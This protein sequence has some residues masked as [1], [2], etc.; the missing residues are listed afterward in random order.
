MRII[1]RTDL[2]HDRVG[3]VACRLDRVDRLEM[4]LELADVPPVG[5]SYI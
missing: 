2:P 1:D 4:K 3:P 5:E